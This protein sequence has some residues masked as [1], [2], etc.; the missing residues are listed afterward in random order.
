MTVIECSMKFD[1][2]AKFALDLV[3]TDVA[4]HDKFIRGLNAMIARDVR[5]T[6]VSGGTTYAQVVEK[7]LTV[8]EA[9]NKIWRESAVRRED[10]GRC[11][12][13]LV[14]VG[15]EALVI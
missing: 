6:T 11:L 1:R 2:L 8:E 3:P 5:I 15:A 7:A 10:A 13:I 12:H 14:L 9:E 4:R